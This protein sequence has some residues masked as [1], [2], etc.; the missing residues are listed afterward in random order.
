MQSHFE[1]EEWY[2]DF[3]TA[4]EHVVWSRKSERL[5]SFS[6]AYLFFIPFM[7]IWCGGVIMATVSLLM[8]AV[9]G[10]ASPFALLF[11][12]PFW[13][14]GAYFI[15]ILFIRPV[16]I[17]KHTRYAVT[18]KRVMEYYRGSFNAVL[19][20]SYTPV[21]ISETSKRGTGTV[22]VGGQGNLYYAGLSL[23][24]PWYNPGMIEI[25]DVTEPRKVYNLIVS[26]QNG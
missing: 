13:A 5:F 14:A 7:T 17:R 8:E 1:Q 6:P 25:I 9:R 15:Y 10:E 23:N 22:T 4:D 19:I 24:A 11:M 26:Q 3:L 21:M 12:V 18:N 16:M 20:G 2:R